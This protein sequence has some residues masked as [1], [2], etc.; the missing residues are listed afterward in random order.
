MR[1]IDADKLIRHL[2]DWALHDNASE[3]R[4]CMKAVAEQPTEPQYLDDI[5]IK[6]KLLEDDFTCLEVQKPDGNYKI[7]ELVKR[8]RWIPIDG[9]AKPVNWLGCYLCSVCGNYGQGIK[10][11][12]YCPSCGALMYEEADHD[13]HL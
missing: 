7:F 2:S 5:G 11:F 12:R 4:E 8:G 9:V 6:E 3:I 13:D 10:H 1:L